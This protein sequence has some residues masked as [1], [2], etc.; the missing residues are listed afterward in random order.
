MSTSLD[1]LERLS[2]ILGVKTEE[3][4]DEPSKALASIVRG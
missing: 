4:M 1:Q 2:E 3:L